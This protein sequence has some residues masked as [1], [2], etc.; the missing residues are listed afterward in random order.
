MTGRLRQRSEWKFFGGV[1]LQ[2]DRVLSLAWWS[3][4]IVRSALPAVFAI[5]M[6]VLVAAV[7]HGRSLAAPLT[8]VGAVFVLLQVLSPLH[9]AV[10]TNLGSR[11]ASWLYDSLTVGCVRPP[12]MGHLEDARLTTDLTMA[13]DFDLGTADR[14]SPSRWTSLHRV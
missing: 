10:G 5:A 9:H 3:M 13:R 8:F 12:G 7:E 14:R 6:G 11:A 1:F 2:A 4:L